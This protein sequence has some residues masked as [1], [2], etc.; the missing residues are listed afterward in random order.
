RLVALKQVLIPAPPQMIQAEIV[1]R[2]A[3][4]KEERDVVERSLQQKEQALSVLVRDL[5]LGETV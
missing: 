5:D 3:L 4:A 1:R 2:A